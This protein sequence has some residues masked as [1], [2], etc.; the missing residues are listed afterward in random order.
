[1]E[2]NFLRAQANNNGHHHHRPEK[3]WGFT[4]LGGR[5]Q[6]RV[7]SPPANSFPLTE[8]KKGS[9]VQIVALPRHCDFPIVGVAVGT[10]LSV[11]GITDRGAVR[12]LVIGQQVTLASAIAQQIYVRPLYFTN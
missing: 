1:M 9:W 8:M 11:L 5:F 3:P 7:E 2:F 6:E 10:Y 12:V 4:Y